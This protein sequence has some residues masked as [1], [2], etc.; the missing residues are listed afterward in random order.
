MG[1]SLQDQLLKAGLANKKQAVRAKKAKNSKE[2]LK[3]TGKEVE[4]EAAV[5]AKKAHEDKLAKDKALNDEKNRQAERAG[6]QA[7][8]LQIV[9]MN[10]IGE[11][12]DVEHHFPDNDVI[13]TIMLTDTQRKAVISGA[14]AIVK[15]SDR[16]DLLPRKAALKIA[17]RD[18]SVVL[19]CNESTEE[20][21]A[22]D[23]Y[24]E[25]KVPDDLMW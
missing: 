13:T 9:A 21:D 3:R 20:T 11:R 8:I 1:K 24:A 6:I 7:Q 25:F 16:Y 17:E 15:T 12:G 14:L 4:D 10:R 19:V 5:L 18:D 2:K 23:E 22:D